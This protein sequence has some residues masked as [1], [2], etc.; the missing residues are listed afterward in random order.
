[1]SSII[2][3][4]SGVVF[5]S[6]ATSCPT[7]EKVPIVR[8][9]SPIGEG[10]PSD[11]RQ[12]ATTGALPRERLS[13]RLAKLTYGAR[14]LRRPGP[15]RL[16]LPEPPWGLRPGGLRS[17]AQARGPAGDAP[18][19]GVIAL[20]ARPCG[21]AREGGHRPP[22]ATLS[23]APE[24]RRP[25]CIAPLGTLPARGT[26]RASKAIP[27]IPAGGCDDG[28][29]SSSSPWGRGGKAARPSG[30][31]GRSPPSCPVPP[32]SRRV[33]SNGALGGGRQP[34]GR[35]HETGHRDGGE[36]WQAAHLG[37]S[38]VPRRRHL[39]D[40][41]PAVPS[42][43]SASP[44]AASTPAGRTLRDRA[45]GGPSADLRPG[46]SSE[47]RRTQ[48]DPLHPALPVEYT[49]RDGGRKTTYR[50]VG[51]V[52]ENTRAT[53]ARPCFRSS[54]TSP[55]ARPNSSPSRPG[56]RARRRATSPSDPHQGAIAARAARQRAPR[57]T[58]LAG[59]TDGPVG[60][61][62]PGP[63]AAP[64]SPARC[65]YPGPREGGRRP[66]SGPAPADRRRPLRAFSVRCCG[67][68]EWPLW[69]NA[70]LSGLAT[71]PGPGFLNASSERRDRT[72][73]SPV[74]FPRRRTTKCE[75]REI[76]TLS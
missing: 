25:P 15:S 32:A 27:V 3:A 56:P 52:F 54:S 33:F 23:A 49:T 48:H 70:I 45:C 42:L 2:R 16:R 43:R 50:R 26:G 74:S 46:V 36:R 59:G 29:A 14:R 11:Q 13:P 6:M 61:Y 65:A 37:S 19:L 22:H 35:R 34:P 68:D 44:I 1:M 39:A 57:G 51:A 58:G 73:R 7:I 20:V 24:G 55:W 64:A 10:Q 4:R 71:P 38:L 21:A 76:R 5:S 62:A 17:L 60:C 41:G 40:H 47:P 12:T 67:S 75:S 53:P 31:V 9:K 18:C 30:P 63:Q 72:E 8:P 66:P 28:S 69:Q